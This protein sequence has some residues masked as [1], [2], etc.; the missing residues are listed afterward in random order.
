MTRWSAL[1]SFYEF[2]VSTNATTVNPTIGAVRPSVSNG[3]PSPTMRLTPEATAAYRTIA[4]ALDRRLDALVALLVLDG[5]K[6][7][8]SLALDVGD[9]NGRS[10]KMSVIVRRRGETSRVDLDKDSARA[11]RRCVAQRPAGPLFTSGRP[12]ARTAPR[13]LTRFGADHLFWRLTIDGTAERV[14]ANALRRFH[15]TTAAD[16]AD[17]E[18]VRAGAG[19]ADLRSVWRYI[20]SAEGPAEVPTNP[21]PKQT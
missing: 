21:A 7:S 13:R 5:L 12:S 20:L 9:V 16:R 2:A 8:E 15:I 10:P 4:T 14:T 18:H 11:V 6:M 3:D 17:L 19:L 1:T